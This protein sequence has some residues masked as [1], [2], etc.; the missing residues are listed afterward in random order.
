M[1]LMKYLAALLMALVLQCSLF[2][3][4]QHVKAVSSIQQLKVINPYDFERSVFVF[5]IGL[6]VWDPASTATE[7]G[8]TVWKANRTNQGRWRLQVISGSG[9]ADTNPTGHYVPV[10]VAGDFSDSPFYVPDAGVDPNNIFQIKP[11]ST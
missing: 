5:G 6:V 8:T 11:S 3:Q 1:T 4:T 9:G 2:S 7:D 10:N